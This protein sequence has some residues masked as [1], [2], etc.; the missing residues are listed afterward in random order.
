MSLEVPAT[1][2]SGTPLRPQVIAGLSQDRSDLEESI[3]HVDP[4]SVRVYPGLESLSTRILFASVL[5]DRLGTQ[6]II[7][8]FKGRPSKKQDEISTIFATCSIMDFSISVP[9][10]SSISTTC[11]LPL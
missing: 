9:S 8:N 10:Y 6:R 11:S 1:Y 2:W 3:P 4:H 7:V 5:S